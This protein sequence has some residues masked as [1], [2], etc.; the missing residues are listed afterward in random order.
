[1]VRYGARTIETGKKTK[2]ATCSIEN[3]TVK[4]LLFSGIGFV[5]GVLVEGFAVG[6]G[7]VS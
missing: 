2:H 4:T 1:M 6:F 3:I 7:L 5:S